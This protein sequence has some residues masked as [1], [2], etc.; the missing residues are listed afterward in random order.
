MK[1]FI[2]AILTVLTAAVLAVAFAA[3]SGDYSGTYKLSSLRID[4]ADG[5]STTVPA[6]GSYMDIS[7]TQDSYV[8]H[9]SDD[10]SW[11]ITMQFEDETESEYGTW[12]DEGGGNLVLTDSYGD[13][14]SA[15][16][17]G[18]TVVVVLPDDDVTYFVTM[19]RQ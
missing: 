15:T 11:Y 19:V 4:S 8:L 1:K 3:C 10:N 2:T 16:V 6:G 9:M 5:S 12:R 18:D 14:L 7:Y 17:D 13:E